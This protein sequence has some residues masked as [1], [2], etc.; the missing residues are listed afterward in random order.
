MDPR[1][2]RRSAASRAATSSASASAGI[3][4][5]ALASLLGSRTLSARRRRHGRPGRSAALR[6]EGEAGHLPVPVRRAV[7]DRPV[8]LQAE[9]GEAVAARAARLDP[10][11]P[12]ADRHDRRPGHVSRRA[13]Q[14]QVRAAR[15]ERGV[16]QRAAAAHARRSPTTS[17]FIKSMHTEAINHDPAITFFQTGSQLAGRPSIGAWVSYGLGSENK[18]LPRS[19]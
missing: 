16:G 10:Q 5:A 9:A 13:D 8:R 12:A 3:G 14:V 15:A 2:E 11:G 17:C 19:S 4:V 6:A 7:A 18:D 1:S